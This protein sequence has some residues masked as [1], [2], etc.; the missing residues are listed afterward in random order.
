[1]TIHVTDMVNDVL[2]QIDAVTL[3]KYPDANKYACRAGM[4]QALLWSTLG[5]LN[6]NQRAWWMEHQ[7]A[8]F[9]S[10]LNEEIK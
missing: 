1:M 10:Q 2:A 6:Q 4:L 8:V 5:H 7:K 9:A 3:R